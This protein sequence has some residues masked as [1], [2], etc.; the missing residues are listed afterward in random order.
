MRRTSRTRRADG[1]HF[2]DSNSTLAY[3]LHARPLMQRLSFDGMPCSGLRA[4]A[5]YFLEHMS[6]AAPESEAL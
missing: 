1:V 5:K 4:R 6:L 2:S 3:H